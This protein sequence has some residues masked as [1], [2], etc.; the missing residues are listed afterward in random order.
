ML[1]LLLLHHFWFCLPACLPGYPHKITILSDCILR[2]CRAWPCLAL[3]GRV[4]PLDLAV[5]SRLRLIS[6][7]CRAK[8]M[9][10]ISKRRAANTFLMPHAACL[11]PRRLPVGNPM[12]IPKFRTATAATVRHFAASSCSQH[13]SATCR[14]RWQCLLAP[15]KFHCNLSNLVVLVV[16][17]G[18]TA[19]ASASSSCRLV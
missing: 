9:T 7:C 6:I 18:R 15:D 12:N 17:G 8:F 10:V 19:S 11:E 16:L 4:Y 2:L 13:A 14:T 5:A 1:L 3:P